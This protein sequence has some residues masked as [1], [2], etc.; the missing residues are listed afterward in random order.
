M[1]LWNPRNALTQYKMT[2]RI[3][4]GA[5]SILWSGQMLS[6]ISLT[7]SDTKSW[8]FSQTAKLS[9]THFDPPFTHCYNV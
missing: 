1:T 7:D 3:V 6:T 5:E 2:D 9:K 8:A 4:G